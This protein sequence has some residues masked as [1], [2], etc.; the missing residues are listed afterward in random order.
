MIQRLKITTAERAKL[1]DPRP[2]RMNGGVCGF[3]FVGTESS[4]EHCRRAVRNGDGS[5]FYCQCDH[6]THGPVQTRCTECYNTVQ[7]ELDQKL[8]LCLDADECVVRVENRL[9]ADPTYQMITE[10]REKSDLRLVAEGKRK[11]RREKREPK[12]KVGACLCCGDATAGGKF[13]PGHDAR[14]VSIWA[15]KVEGSEVTR[16]DAIAKF[17]ELGTS[18]ALIAKLTRKLD[19]IDA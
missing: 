6:A 19:L 8:W 5:I 11:P 14:L 12:P 16:E 9:K 7:A 13:L 3:C 2:A 1:A 18:D 15:G 10:I 4:H 17:V